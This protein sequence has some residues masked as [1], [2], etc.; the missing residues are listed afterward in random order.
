MKK[1]LALAAIC[2]VVVFLLFLPSC[3]NNASDKPSASGKDDSIKKVLDRGEYLAVHVA[4]CLD[5]HSTRDINKFAGPVVTGT[6]GQGGFE[7]GPGV[8]AP[9]KIYARNI[10]PDN[11][12]GIG[13]WTDEEIMR[14]VTHGISKNGDTLFPIMPYLRYNRMAKSDLLAIIA[15]IR[16]LKPI[17]NKVPARQ[18]MIPIAMAYPAP[19]LQASVDGNVLPP[20]SDKVAYG[21]YLGNMAHCTDCHTPITPKGEPDM[22]KLF[23]GGHVCDVGA[24]KVAAA[25]ITMD[26]ATGIG[27]WTEERFMNKFTPY[28][29]EKNYNFNP[30]KE[31]T[32][33]PLPAMAGMTDA[34]LHALWAWVKTIPA[35]SN[36]VEK[37]PK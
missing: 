37:Y 33:M 8:G 36:K 15:Y 18:L 27:T 4:A 10:T 31:N 24:F 17:K 5:C 28:R 21:A 3:N 14:A 22:T 34:D 26:S 6:E 9:G 19:A 35:V 25:N 7:F 20:A 12:T 2:S 13:T 30:G 32:V 29:E 1:L 23:A 11:E 16:T